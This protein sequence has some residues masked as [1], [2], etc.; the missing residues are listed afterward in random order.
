[1]GENGNGPRAATRAWTHPVTWYC[2]DGLCLSRALTASNSAP[3]RPP[4]H[5]WLS[6]ST[7][8]TLSCLKACVH[9]NVTDN[10]NEAAVGEGTL[11]SKTTETPR[12]STCWQPFPARFCLCVRVRVLV[13]TMSDSENQVYECRW[14]GQRSP[15]YGHKGPS[16]PAV[17]K[18]NMEVHCNR[19]QSV[20]RCTKQHMLSFIWRQQLLAQLVILLDKTYR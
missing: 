3:K 16:R 15:C 2:A 7:T 12:G 1:M 20:H 11:K 9:H 18:E 10:E 5:R 17:M 6:R 14:L 4:T 8:F 13:Q 19:T